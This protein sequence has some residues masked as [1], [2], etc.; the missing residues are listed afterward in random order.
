MNTAFLAINGMFLFFILLQLLYI[1]KALN[2]IGD[3][4]TAL[5]ERVE[6]REPET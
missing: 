5:R 4:L 3:E 1:S 2:R 6:K